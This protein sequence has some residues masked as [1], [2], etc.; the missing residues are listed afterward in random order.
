MHFAMYAIRNDQIGSGLAAIGIGV[1]L[2]IVL[3]WLFAP[4]PPRK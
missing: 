1:G 3:S 4:R 2:F